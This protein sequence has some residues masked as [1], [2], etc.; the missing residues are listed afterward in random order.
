MAAP[1]IPIVPSGRADDLLGILV[2][3]EEVR[4]ARLKIVVPEKP[5]ATRAWLEP[6]GNVFGRLL[7][8]GLSILPNRLLSEVQLAFWGKIA[9]PNTF[10]LDAADPRLE[11]AKTLVA[12]AGGRPALLC[13]FT[14]PPVVG[15]WLNLNIELTRQAMWALRLLRPSA[16]R[17]KLIV[18]VDP[19]ALD[20]FGLFM[21]GAYAGFMGSLHLGF[22]RLATHRTPQSRALVGF[23]SWDRVIFRLIRVL[24]ERGEAGLPLG[25]GV[26]T[27]SRALYSAKEFVWHCRRVRPRDRSPGD[28]LRALEANADFSRFLSSGLVG[29]G[30]RRSA[31]RTFEAYMLAVVAGA[32]GGDD[33]REGGP[34]ADL[35]ALTEAGRAA[36]FAVAKA[37]GLDGAGADGA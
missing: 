3:A 7:Y 20:A 17:P 33:K 5:A 37:A 29:A 22:D 23:T 1:Y 14:H 12:H 26:P 18:A 32:W 6:M 21:E 24:R 19:F 2:R 4:Y 35:G 28:A 34:S 10:P 16:P 27:T 13:V 30:L 31:W 8:L 36:A 9:A 15:E 25:G 11:D